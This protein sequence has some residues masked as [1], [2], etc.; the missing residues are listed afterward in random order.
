MRKFAPKTFH[1]K[2]NLVTLNEIVLCNMQ[3]RDLNWGKQS[4]TYVNVAGTGIGLEFPLKAAA[5][6][7]KKRESDATVRSANK[8]VTGKIY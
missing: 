6:E 5:L 2:P 3:K 4:S 8:T 7:R 1:K